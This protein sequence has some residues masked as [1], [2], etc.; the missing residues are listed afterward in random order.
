MSQETRI[1][2]SQ[3]VGLDKGTI[4]D[5]YPRY[6][7]LRATDPVHWNEGLRAWLL[8]RCCLK[9]IE[10]KW[11]VQIL[12]R[13]FIMGMAAV[14]A[15]IGIA[16]SGADPALTATPRPTSVAVPAAVPSLSTTATAVPTTS[17]SASERVAE[18]GDTVVVH[19]RG[20]LDDGEEFDSSF[21][22]DPLTFTLGTGQLIAGFE[23]AI[24]GM[25]VGDTVTVRIEPEDAYGERSNDFILEYP[26]SEAPDDIAVGQVVRL[27][28]GIPATI[29]E[30][31]DEIFRL[32]ANHELAGKAL[33]FEIE[34][35]EIR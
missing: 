25:S 28:N 5:P 35:V 20:T 19:Y 31:T 33:K 29:V 6:D 11:K 17:V 22:G 21:G 18:D 30:V 1:S 13:S 4:I 23:N 32:D 34:V 14:L 7:Y 27:P 15:A 24:R 12:K 3:S 2:S 10:I 16:C 9:L 26:R 8:T